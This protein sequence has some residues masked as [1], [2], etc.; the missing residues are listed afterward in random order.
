MIKRL[1]SIAFI[2]L[3][4]AFVA[5]TW[6]SNAALAQRARSISEARPDSIQDVLYSDYKGVRLGMTAADVRAKLGEPAVKADD[7]YFYV[8]SDKETAQI[9]YDALGKVKG[10]ST[11]YLDGVGAPDYKTVVGGEVQAKADGSL[12]KMVRY[13][14]LGFWVSYNRSAGPVPSVTVTIQRIR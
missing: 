13:E 7:Q 11:D 8:F 2:A 5:L 10:I 1:K 6:G 12:Y 4:C 3:G 14:N 9:V